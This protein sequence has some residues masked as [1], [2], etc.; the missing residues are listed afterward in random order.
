MASGR[1]LDNVKREKRK[2]QDSVKKKLQSCF[3][4]KL[5]GSLVV[6]HHSNPRYRLVSVRLEVSWHTK[7][8]LEPSAAQS[9][10]SSES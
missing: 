8:L 9:Q 3:K 10:K 2:L 4:E 7:S 6:G 1:C 5:H